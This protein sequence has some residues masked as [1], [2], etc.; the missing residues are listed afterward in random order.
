MVTAMKVLITGASGWVGKYV[1]AD[2]REDYQ[3]RSFDIQEPASAEVE[4][5]C[6]DLTV[7][8]QVL[9]AMEGVDAVVHLG[10]I[11]WDT[12]EAKKIWDV[13]CTGTFHVLQAA[14]ETGVKKAVVASS[15]CAVGFIY[16]KKP[17]IPDYFPVDEEHPL[18][19]DDTYGLSKLVDEKICY[20]FAQRYDMAT[21]CLR[22]APVWFPEIRPSTK[23]F[24]EGVKEPW[25]N[26][27]YLW[28]YVDARDV[29]QAIRLSLE[30]SPV[31]WHA[32]N[33]GADDVC[34]EVPSLDLIR[35][36]YP[37][38]PLIKNTGWFLQDQCRALWNISKAKEQLGYR[39][40]FDWRGYL[41]Q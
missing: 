15:I 23:E 18:K 24:L 32:Y 8:E 39:P 14:A 19:P 6:G 33:V 34:T 5:M 41:K 29:V 35:E 31:G 26:K 28:S 36:F 10:A 38:V 9:R 17:F 13:N 7:F 12:G 25:K 4:F 11:P 27:Q 3:I 16:W 2:L 21:T 30:V 1:L 22:L 40:Q 20:A 37:E